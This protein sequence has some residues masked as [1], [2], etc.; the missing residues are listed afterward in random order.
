VRPIEYKILKKIGKDGI[1]FDGI[2]E[3]VDSTSRQ[4]MKK[5]YPD[6]CHFQSN[7]YFTKVITDSL[8]RSK[9]VRLEGN[10]YVKNEPATAKKEE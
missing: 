7:R 8:L 3:I 2:E 9:L 4:E 1:S 6:D 10:K 5:S